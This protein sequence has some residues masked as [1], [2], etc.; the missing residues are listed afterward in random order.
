MYEPL[1][2]FTYIGVAVFA[3]ALL[4]S[5]RFVYYYFTEPGVRTSICSR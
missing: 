5:L 2:V 1:K 3:S 4:I